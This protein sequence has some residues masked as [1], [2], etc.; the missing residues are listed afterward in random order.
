MNDFKIN[1]SIK[2]I[3]DMTEEEKNNELNKIELT[4]LLLKKEMII[5]E[6]EN[7]INFHIKNFDNGVH[8]ENILDKIQEL[9]EKYK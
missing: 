1:V 8:L 5:T 2:D 7:W 3:L 6:L 4:T 9:K